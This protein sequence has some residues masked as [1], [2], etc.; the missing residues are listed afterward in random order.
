MAY[1]QQELQTII[2]RLETALGRGELTVEF[3][4]RRVTYQSAEEIR[5]RITYF[6]GLLNTVTGTTRPKQAFAVASKGFD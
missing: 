2:A 4:D 5:S 1:T 6:T 3:G